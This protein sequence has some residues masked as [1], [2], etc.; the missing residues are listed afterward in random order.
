MSAN[1]EV[2]IVVQPPF[3][4]TV[5][6][7]LSPM[8]VAAGFPAQNNIS[9]SELVT[10]TA[11][12]LD[13]QGKPCEMHGT[14]IANAMHMTADQLPAASGGGGGGGGSNASSSSS[15]EHWYQ[16][17]FD[18]LYIDLVGHYHIEIR[19]NKLSS[20]D[21]YD[22]MVPKPQTPSA[23]WPNN[24]PTRCRVRPLFSFCF[25][26]WHPA[27]QNAYRAALRERDIFRARDAHH[28]NTL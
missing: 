3:M 12:L 28:Q 21:G 17:W 8:V 20:Y 2:K 7:V 23:W 13:A 26:T 9:S 1:V 14:R 15:S 22:Y 4:T 19:V 10:A 6:H 5:G 16:F 24:R 11:K 25:P 18:S 27:N